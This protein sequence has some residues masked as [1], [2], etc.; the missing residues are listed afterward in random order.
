VNLREWK[1]APD[2]IVD[3]Q[4][5]R[6]LIVNSLNAVNLRDVESFVD[7]NFEKGLKDGT[8]LFLFDSFD[9][10]PEVLSSSEVDASIQRYRDAL[11]QF[12]SGFN[13][14]RGIVASRDFR[15]PSTYGLATFRIVPL[16]AR[17]RI[18]LIKKAELPLEA[19]RIF[20]AALP[21]AED[22][23]QRLVDNPMFLGLLC[24]QLRE[25]GQFPTNSYTVF[26]DYISRRIERD[27]PAL[28]K[29]FAVTADQ[30]LAT[31]EQ[32]AFVIGIEPSLGLSPSVGSLIE[33][34]IA[35]GLP[36]EKGQLTLTLSALT[37]TKLM[38]TDPN[39]QDQNLIQ[40][41]FAHRRFQEYFATRVVLK[42]LQAVPP[43]VLLKD[44]RWRETTVTILQTQPTDAVRPNYR[45]SSANARLPC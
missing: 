10:I 29:R 43:R 11:Y 6:Q 2:E 23:I 22:A 30:L 15:G 5:V 25:G 31:A 35:R 41:A 13:R 21:N 26:E 20:L 39:Q 44:G 19:R 16:S 38:R 17:R 28:L 12:L 4:L 24:E 32:V 7:E 8:W 33:A 45:F 37:Y 34:M 18:E 36:T 9:E 1:V 27:S 14:C 40:V 3:A 42:D